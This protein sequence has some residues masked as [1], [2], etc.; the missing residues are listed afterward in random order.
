MGRYRLFGIHRLF[1]CAAR[2]S[3]HGGSLSLREAANEALEGE[4]I[5]PVCLRGLLGFR[6]LVYGLRRRVGRRRAQAQ[7]ARPR[8]LSFRPKRRQ[9]PHR[10][11]VAPDRAEPAAPATPAPFRLSAR[12]GRPAGDGPPPRVVSRPTPRFRARA[13][14][15]AAERTP[16]ARTR[17]STAATRRARRPRTA[18]ERRGVCGARGLRGGGSPSRRRR[19]SL[20]SVWSPASRAVSFSTNRAQ[21]SQDATCSRIASSSGT[22]PTT[23]SSSRTRS[24]VS[25]MS[26]MMHFPC[27]ARSHRSTADAR[28]AGASSRY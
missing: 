10:S 22:R 11:G 3:V 27:A 7:R 21:S 5:Y 24:Q 12:F 20:P 15:L 19:L 2:G 14:P 25:G 28:A 8:N 18:I 1:L 17:P 23:A 13:K 6:E 26:L 9:R 16:H 4:T